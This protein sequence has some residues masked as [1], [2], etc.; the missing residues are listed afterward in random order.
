MPRLGVIV[1]GCCT[2]SVSYGGE[3]LELF[4]EIARLTFDHVLGGSTTCLLAP[5]DAAKCCIP[6]I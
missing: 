5:T 3:S 2:R 6:P 1:L 4:S